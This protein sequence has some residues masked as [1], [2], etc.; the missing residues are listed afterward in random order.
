MRNTRI[1]AAMLL[2]SSFL[3]ACSNEQVIERLGF[4]HTVAFDLAD[5]KKGDMQKLLVTFSL[6]QVEEGAKE[7]RETLTTTAYSSKDAHEKLSRKTNRL[8]VAGQ[9]RNVLIGLSLAQ[10]GLSNKLDTLLRD[11][12]IGPRVKVTIVDGNANDVLRKKFSEHPRTSQYIDRML[13]KEARSHGFM[14]TNVYTFMRDFFDDGID[15]T[16]PIIKAGKKDIT[17]EGMVLFKGDR[18]VHILPAKQARLLLMLRQNVKSNEISINVRHEGKE[19]EQRLMYTNIMS[20]RKIKVERT[21][22][23]KTKVH[24]T[25]KLNGSILEYNGDMNLREWGN[26]YKLERLLTQYIRNTLKKTIAELQKKKVDPLGIGQHVRNSMTYE[27]WKALDWESFYSSLDIECHV[28]VRIKDIGE[29]N[30]QSI[31]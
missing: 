20:K 26:Q 18:A 13:E 1:L 16:A 9:A 5:G 7:S 22:S 3:T 19:T 10:S 8:L 30:R 12:S 24:I 6:P 28:Q 29:F 11:P 23:Q 25:L 14:E 17:L 2:L 4:I 27:E 21:A 31:H 15:P